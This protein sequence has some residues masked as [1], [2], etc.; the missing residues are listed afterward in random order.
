M[1]SVSRVRCDLVGYDNG[2]IEVLCQVLQQR[3]FLHQQLL[4]LLKSKT[5]RSTGQ[6]E[7]QV[8]SLT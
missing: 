4:S 3:G 2:Y 5:I 1:P 6:K 8:V 7:A